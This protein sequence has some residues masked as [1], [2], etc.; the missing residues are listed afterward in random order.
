M[1]SWTKLVFFLFWIVF[2]ASFIPAGHV[3]ATCVPPGLDWRLLPTCDGTGHVMWCTVTAPLSPP[4][5]VQCCDEASECTGHQKGHIGGTGDSIS[6]YCNH[7]TQIGSIRTAIGCI[8]A[9]D[10]KAL[11]NQIVTWTISLAAGLSL[12]TLFYAGFVMTTSGG[13]TKRVHA[14]R[15]SVTSTLLGLAF[16]VLAVIILNF[17]GLRILD[18]GAIGFGV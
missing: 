18:L 13:D 10:P 5:P 7:N 8:N 16:I 12:A 1:A 14:A 6:L 3:S 15:E 17:L 4:N 9:S 2:L 11:I